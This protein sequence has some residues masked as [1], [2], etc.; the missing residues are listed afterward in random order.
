MPNKPTDLD[1]LY[2]EMRKP[3]YVIKGIELDVEFDYISSEEKQQAIKELENLIEA[4][5]LASQ[6]GECLI[7]PDDVIYVP[8]SGAIDYAASYFEWFQ[9]AI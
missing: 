8:S 1:V 5:Q 3:Y 7:H 9:E 2:F 6:T 4:Q